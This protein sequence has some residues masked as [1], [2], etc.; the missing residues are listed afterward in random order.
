MAIYLY[1]SC[2]IFPELQTSISKHILKPPCGCAPDITNATCLK[3]KPRS[4]L[5]RFFSYY[6]LQLRKWQISCP[7][8]QIR[9]LK[10]TADYVLF[11]FTWMSLKSIPIFT[12]HHYPIS[13]FIFQR[14]YLLTGPSPS[15]QTIPW[16]PWTIV[17][18]WHDERGLFKILSLLISPG[19][20]LHFSP[21]LL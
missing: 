17:R 20:F 6:F 12:S 13:P 16:T 15:L 21:Q 19:I 4:Y 3:M 5:K 7:L 1:I 14:Q 10:I 9:N 18:Y 11:L 2:L 8:A